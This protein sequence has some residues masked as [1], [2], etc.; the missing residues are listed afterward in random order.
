MAVLV[1]LEA[2]PSGVP[3]KAGLQVQLVGVG[4][5]GSGHLGRFVTVCSPPYP[6]FWLT[7]LG[8]KVCKFVLSMNGLT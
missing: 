6:R 4:D 1:D 2:V 5:A 3:G 7:I 8:F